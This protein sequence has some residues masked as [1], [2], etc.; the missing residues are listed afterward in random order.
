MNVDNIW[1]LLF[2]CISP[3]SRLKSI[4]NFFFVSLIPWIGR[5]QSPHKR[6]CLLTWTRS[7]RSIC[8]NCFMQVWFEVPLFFLFISLSFI[9]FS[10][11]KR[12]IENSFVD[13][14][15]SFSS[16]TAKMFSANNN[17]WIFFQMYI[18]IYPKWCYNEYVLTKDDVIFYLIKRRK[19]MG[20][21]RIK[22]RYII[23]TIVVLIMSVLLAVTVLS[24][25]NSSAKAEHQYH[26]INYLI[27]TTVYT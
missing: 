18:D 8:R 26:I 5:P 7:M 15:A 6:F 9:C 12:K 10:T 1:N 20:N 24:F 21:H 4:V 2:F 23:W 27:I 16:L 11:A 13:F 17:L 19:V 3:L 25:Q 14:F 22:S